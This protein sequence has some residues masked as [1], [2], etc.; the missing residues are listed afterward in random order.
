MSGNENQSFYS[1]LDSVSQT[2]NA[3]Q[4]NK[5]IKEAE[6]TEDSREPNE[7][8]VEEIRHELKADKKSLYPAA[9]LR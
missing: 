7:E 8:E 1:M 4:Q 6:F 9:S 5:K 2:E 3:V